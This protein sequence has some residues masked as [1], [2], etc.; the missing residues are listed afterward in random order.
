MYMLQTPTMSPNK[1][2]AAYR[3]NPALL[4]A[5]RAM[6]DRDGV[7]MAVQIERAVEV[8]LKKRGIIVK[9]ERGTRGKRGQRS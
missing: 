5:M 2:T 9:A 4:D 1:K 7:P 3:L 6:K 8:W